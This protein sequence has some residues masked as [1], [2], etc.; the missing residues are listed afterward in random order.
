MFTVRNYEDILFDKVNIKK[1]VENKKCVFFDVYYEDAYLLILSDIL[2]IVQKSNYYSF[3]DP[4][5]RFS[6]FF[7]QFN[8]FVLS[9]ISTH[10]VY[11]HI[12][13][14]K[15]K[16]VYDQ[17]N[18][19]L[20]FANGFNCETTLFDIENNEIDLDRLKVHDDVRIIL[21][22]KNIW[23]NQDACGVNFK[24]CQIQRVEPLG[25]HRSL[26]KISSTIPV[27]P[28][29]PPNVPKM[30]NIQNKIVRPTLSEIKKSK[31]NLRKTNILS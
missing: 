19:S 27:P 22:V 14:N 17:P 13:L 25:L 20:R 24:I 10:P 4:N 2:Q 18:D 28:A 26:F 6:I 31:N 11:K 1:P 16:H 3:V 23:T 12:F 21:Y 8:D 30:T 9:K 15:R 5:K 7:I 29:M